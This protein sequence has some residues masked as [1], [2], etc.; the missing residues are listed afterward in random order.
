M[1]TNILIGWVLV[2]V[3]VVVAGFRWNKAKNK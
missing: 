2:L 3:I 1:F